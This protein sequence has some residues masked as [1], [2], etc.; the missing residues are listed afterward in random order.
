MPDAG[1]TQTATLTVSPADTSTQA[2]LSVRAPDGT[3]SAPTATP[4]SDRGTWTADVPYPVAG[5]Y[6]LTWT[7]LGTGAGVQ[8]YTVSV[9]PLLPVTGR[10]YATST[11]VANWMNAAPRVDTDALLVKVARYL[12]N[13]MLK[14]SFYD[15][16]T[17]GMPTGAAVIVALRDASCALVAWWNI[18]GITGEDPDREYTTMSIGSATL[19]K[20]AGAGGAPT[21][22]RYSLEAAEI[23]SGAGLIGHAP[24]SR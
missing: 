15:V 9:A 18:K 1:D 11:D 17:D 14:T 2:T 23:L 16:D 3:T 6:V 22:P 19:T 12:D 24:W 21:D 7:V 20:S 5:L 8:Q 13:H 4:T 10:T